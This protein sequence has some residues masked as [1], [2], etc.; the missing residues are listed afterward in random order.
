MMTT[1]LAE[2]EQRVGSRMQAMQAEHVSVDD[3]RASLASL[4]DGT[5]QEFLNNSTRLE[6]LI[7]S[8]NAKFDEHRA[9]FQKEVGDFQQ[10][11]VDG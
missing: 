7:N 5:R 11:G 6:Q 8:N 3:A 10:A 2:F 1:A 4:A 9:A